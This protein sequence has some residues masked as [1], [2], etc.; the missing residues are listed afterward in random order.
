[1]PWNLNSRSDLS[2]FNGMV[3]VRTM[4]SQGDAFSTWA[5]ESRD[6]ATQEKVNRVNHCT[7]AGTI[8]TPDHEVLPLKVER[9]VA[10]ASYVSY[11]EVKNSHW[12]NLV[13]SEARR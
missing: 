5:D 7:L 12:L 4:L 8:G 2:V 10:Q 6:L 13:T 3:D 9:E 1:M 11:C